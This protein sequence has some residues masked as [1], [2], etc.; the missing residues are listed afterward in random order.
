MRNKVFRDLGRHAID[1]I[2]DTGRHTRIGKASDQFGRGGRGLL[3]R[4]D[5]DGTPGGQ[6][7]GQLADHL[8]DREVPGREGGDRPHRFLDHELID[9]LCASGNNAAIGSAGFLGEPVDHVGAGQYLALRFGQRF[10]LFHRQHGGDDIDAGAQQIGRL[11]HHF[12][13]VERGHLAPDFD[14]R[15]GSFQRPIQIAAVGVGNRGDD[16][17]RG[18]VDDRDGAPGGGGRPDAV[19]EQRY[20]RIH[21]FPCPVRY[22]LASGRHV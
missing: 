1:Q 17:T 15:I 20:V 2:D 3:R 21:R 6:R 9:S 14:A 16:L 13:A 22:G 12:R 8:V 7:A 19:D 4:L 5:D 10:A 11:A 18:G